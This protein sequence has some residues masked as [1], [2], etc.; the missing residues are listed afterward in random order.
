MNDEKYDS[1]ASYSFK[2]DSQYP[3]FVP[4]IL[5]LWTH[6]PIWLSDKPLY[7]ESI[8]HIYGISYNVSGELVKR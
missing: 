1:H 3:A 8:C 2:M 5:S 4:H 7:L 6:S